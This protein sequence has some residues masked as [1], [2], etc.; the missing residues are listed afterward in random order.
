M[1]EK[2]DTIHFELSNICNA[3]CPM[4][5]RTYYG[6]DLNFKKQNF[7]IKY[8]ENID[9]DIKYVYFCGNYGESVAHPYFMDVLD[10][11]YK[12]NIY[13]RLDI[14]TNGGIKNKKFWK[15]LADY[16][17]KNNIKHT[18]YFGIDGLKD[19]NHIYRKN[20]IW[21]KLMENVSEFINNGGNAIWNYLVF[22]HNQHQIKDAE[23]L[24]K[25]MGFKNINFKHTG[26]FGNYD[27]YP[28]YSNKEFLYNI[29]KSDFAIEKD[30]KIKN[31]VSC[32]AKN[33]NKIYIDFKNHVMPCCWTGKLVNNLNIKYKDQENFLKKVRLEN[34]DEI[35]LSKYK[36]SK[37]VKSNVFDKINKF[38]N[39][40]PLDVCKTNCSI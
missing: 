4:C 29:Y 28:V 13:T 14:H 5:T 25:I 23:E 3:S 27:Y 31:I 10:H 12:K 36:L 15:N 21:D 19:T 9:Y 17:V 26:R 24:S 39:T 20:V 37:I 18:V 1:Y 6:K 35:S 34:Y 11:F 38:L 22:K 16:Y 8:L 32:I 30:N 2:I 7:N 40:T 33:K